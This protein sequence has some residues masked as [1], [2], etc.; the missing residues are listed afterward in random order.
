MSQKY[1]FEIKVTRR[2]YSA[3]MDIRGLEPPAHSMVMCAALQDNGEWILQGSHDD[4][5][6]LLR[7]VNM[8]IDEQVAP[9][10]NMPSLRR[11]RDYITPSDDDEDSGE[12]YA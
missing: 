7:D 9:K 5:D 10:K 11:I 6:A 4:F 1:D 3:L 8:E 12:S 2:E